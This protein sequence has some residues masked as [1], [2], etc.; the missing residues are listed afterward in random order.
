MY[1]LNAPCPRIKYWAEDGS[2][3][4]KHVANYINPLMLELNPSAQGC[5][6]R[7]FTGDFA[8]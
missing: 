4:L 1:S 3:E 8:S 5:L 7:F 2:V 6:A